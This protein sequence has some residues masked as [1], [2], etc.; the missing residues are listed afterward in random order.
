MQNSVSL[1]LRPIVLA[2][3][4][5]ASFPSLAQATNGSKEAEDVAAWYNS[6]DWLNGLKLTPHS[7]V[8]Q[9]ELS[10]QYHANKV[11]WDKT[12]AFLKA[13]DLATLE[14]GRYIIDSANVTAFVSE[15]PVKDMDQ[16]NWETHKNFNDLQYIIK[17]KA[18][19]G[20]TPVTDPNAKV[21]VP[22]DSKGDTETYSV[23]GGAY[24]VAEPGTF[25]I[26][27]PQD[28][29][30]PAFKVEGYDVVKKILIKVRVPSE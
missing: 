7:S 26:F 4:L 13:N 17:G 2:A 20:V 30:K 27:S 29:H 8:N 10:R 22:Y 12:F 21:T 6:R 23:A 14:P 5:L 25:F 9:K 11:W 3:F 18:K 1:W 24:Y 15:V 16:V 19:M 28:I